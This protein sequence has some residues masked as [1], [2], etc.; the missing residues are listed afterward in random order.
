MGVAPQARGVF[1]HRHGA[2]IIGSAE[3][4][5]GRKGTG[6]HHA[7]IFKGSADIQH[8]GAYHG[9]IAGDLAR[10]AHQA[11]LDGVGAEGIIRIEHHGG[12]GRDD[13]GGHAGTGQLQIVVF[14]AAIRAE[15]HAVGQDGAQ[16][17]YV[18]NR[19]HDAVAR[20]Q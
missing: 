18:G 17:G 14:A 16:S 10:R 1:D 4:H 19:R 5:H 11:G 12:G 20:G 6:G 7:L 8:P 15:F 2:A 9:G 13:G 3:R